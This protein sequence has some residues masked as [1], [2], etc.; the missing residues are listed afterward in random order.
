M[1]DAS[2]VVKWFVEEEGT[3]KALEIRDDF[4]A[5]DVALHAPSHLPFEVLNALRFSTL[6]TEERCV[7]A[8][9]ALQAYGFTYHPLAGEMGRRALHL[10]FRGDLSVYDAAYLA[11]ARELATKVV[12]ADKGW[13]AA[14]ESETLLLADYASLGAL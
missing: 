4:V 12:T 14:G 8:L 10:A 3:D 6:C 9:L 7:Q 13:V 2:V 1:V 11:L 5:G